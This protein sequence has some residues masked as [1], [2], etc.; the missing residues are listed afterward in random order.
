MPMESPNITDIVFGGDPPALDDAAETWFEASKLSRATVWWDSFG[1]L[2]L[3]SAPWL[4]EAATRGGKRFDHR[5]G[6]DLAEPAAL[7]TCLGEVLH[8]RASS[9][10]HDPTAS[11]TEAELAALA[12]AAYGTTTSLG[13]AHSR[14]TVPSGGALFPID[15][16]VAIG[17]VSELRP[18]LYHVDPLRR[19]LAHLGT[20]GIDALAR[21][22][23]QPETIEP[24]AA[25]FIVA[26]SFWRSRFKYGQR[27]LRFVHLEAGHVAQ[28]LLL[29]ATALGLS[30]RPIGGFYDDEV[31][32]V[33]GLDGINEAPLY[34]IPIGRPL[35]T[36]DQ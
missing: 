22:T 15:L 32:D 23:V 10:D 7:H 30:H 18:G 36:E 9:D 12:W 29:A 6:A 2:L 4:Q 33:L 1:L 26:A 5:P 28:N 17:R 21:A 8:R 13:A 20:G 35:G 16:Y 3:E 27:S 31:A 19:R 34:L 25:V 11:L 24:A 14:R